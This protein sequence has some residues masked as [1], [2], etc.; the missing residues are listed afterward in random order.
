M[1][2]MQE[3]V[4]PY[5]PDH[6]V[7]GGSSSAVTQVDP[8]LRTALFRRSACW[9]WLWPIA[10]LLLW[11]GVDYFYT[12]LEFWLVEVP[13]FTP[14]NRDSVMGGVVALSS[15]MWMLGCAKQVVL[16]ARFRTVSGVFKHLFAGLVASGVCV[17]IV[18]NSM[19]V[20][21]PIIDYGGG[22]GPAPNFEP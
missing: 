15:L 21:K 10:G 8:T 12:G 11:F 16:L 1:A 18:L 4:N 14:P 5:K 19:N 6:G 2:T 13:E 9:A 17:L 20:A 22:R 7:S 3:P